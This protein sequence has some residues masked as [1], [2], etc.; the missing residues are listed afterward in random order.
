MRALPLVLALAVA[1]PALAEQKSQSKTPK[2]NRSKVQKSSVVSKDPVT[3]ELR[4][5]TAQELKALD[6]QAQAEGRQALISPIEQDRVEL[7]PDGS[8]VGYLGESHMSHV[9]VKRGADGSLQYL[10]VD[11]DA[12]KSRALTGAASPVLKAEE[13]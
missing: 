7:R 9:V 3:G 12:K 2:P 5:P 11:G 1:V 13:R 6:A 4:P 8:K 10:C